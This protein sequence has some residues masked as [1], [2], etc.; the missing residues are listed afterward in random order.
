MASLNISE[1]RLPQDGRF[2]IRVRSRRIDVRLSTMPIQYGE[3]VV[4]RLLDQSGGILELESLGI[5]DDLLPR[6]LQLIQKPSG[7]ILVTGPT[8]SGKTTTLYAALNHINRAE[9]KILT[10]EDPV[11]YRLPRINQVQVHARI[12]LDFAR[13]LRTALRQDP[14][15]IMVGEMR[16]R[17]TVEI[18]LR[19]AMT[20]HLVLST[21][22]TNNAIDTVIR[23]L[24]MGAEG[25]M[26]ATSLN[27]VMAQRLVRRVCDSC[28]EPAEPDRHQRAWLQSQASTEAVSGARF[29]RGAGCAYCSNTGYRGRI[30]VYELLEIDDP[31]T[32][33]LRCMDTA[34]FASAARKQRGFRPLVF[35]ALDCA[36]RGITS[37]DEVVRL[38]GGVDA[39]TET[40]PETGIGQEE[41]P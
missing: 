31:L 16:D 40:M 38:A 12:G 28:G 6:V 32:D 22:H 24:D 27:A 30:G 7:M 1:R 26:V 25:F 29:M 34:A 41:A 3:S 33:A 14:D 35:N 18:G 15:I 17:E 20:G 2:S 9:A 8:G 10:V 37:V 36:L 11:E 21:L 23:L 39:Y 4:M 19:A 5:P 13:V